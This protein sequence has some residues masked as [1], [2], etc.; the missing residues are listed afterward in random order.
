MLLVFI[1][2]PTGKAMGQL[3]VPGFYKFP[4]RGVASGRSGS[5]SVVLGHPLG[6]KP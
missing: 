4:H 6:S 1:Q 2:A 5:K 3:A